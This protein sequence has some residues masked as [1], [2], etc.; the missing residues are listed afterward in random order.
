VLYF[1]VVLRFIHNAGMA[2]DA[3]GMFLI[4]GIVGVFVFQFIVNVGMV[5][6]YLPVTGI[7]L[8]LMSYGGSSAL[9]VFLSVGLINSVRV[10]RFVN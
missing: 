4:L 8:P 6:G 5:V 2:P 1:L 7:P 3:G 9:S 10:R